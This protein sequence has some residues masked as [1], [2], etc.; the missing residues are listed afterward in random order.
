MANVSFKRGTAAQLGQLTSF[1]EGAFYLTTDTNRLY[2]ANSSTKLSDLNKYVRVVKDITEANALT[3]TED[4]DFVYINEGN[5]FAVKKNGSWT[6]VNPDTNT[7]IDT[8]V[9]GFT[10]GSST[11]KDGAIT[12]PITISQKKRNGN[13][14]QEATPVK[15][16]IVI[17]AN[18]LS[19]ATGISVGLDGSVDSNKLTLTPSGAGANANKKV[20]ITAG[21]NVSITNDASSGITI[22]AT[23][24]T[25]TLEA[26]KTTDQA[27]N[28]TLVL[29]KGNSTQNTITLKGEDEGKIS[30]S[31]DDKGNITIAHTDLNKPTHENKSFGASTDNTTELGFGDGNNGTF[32]AVESITSPDG[33]ITGY[34]TKTYKMP[35][36]TKHTIKNVSITTN[37]KVSVT[38]DNNQPVTSDAKLYYTIG[39]ED[40]EKK[41]VYIGN[42]LDVYTTGEID[43]KLQGINAMVYRGTVVPE[44][45]TGNKL[46]KSG[47]Q[48]GDTYMVSASGSFVLN[49]NTVPQELKDCKAGDLL[50]ATGEETEGVIPSN[51]LVWTYVPS[52]DDTDTHYNLVTVAAKEGAQ[53]KLTNSVNN[54]F[55]N[56]N[57]VSDGELAKVAYDSSTKEVKIS[58]E[59]IGLAT[60]ITQVNTPVST[61]NGG[62]FINLTGLT[63]KNGHIAK[64]EQQTVNLPLYTFAADDSG[65]TN[66]KAGSTTLGSIKFIDGTV[67]TAQYDKNKKA[68]KINHANVSPTISKPGTN[69]TATQLSYGDEIIAVT[70]AEVSEQGHITALTAKKYKMPNAPAAHSYSGSVAKDKDGIINIS[71]AL[72]QGNTDLGTNT[73][74]IVSDS[75]STKVDTGKKQITVELEWGSFT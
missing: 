73:I 23:D 33:H 60:E 54:N 72:K 59:T 6:Q 30:V 19:T 75:L 43:K 70:D 66:F 63:L 21:S 10:A 9:S 2:V 11:S 29:K 27:P 64:I 25:Y 32:T 58:H 41:T 7:D 4:G 37:G 52:G 51:K 39:K 3:G 1:V 44:A 24:S 42:P 46:P 45:S 22:S 35:S 18:S 48:N 62:N 65:V 74:K 15:G 49:S 69:T 28:S 61:S 14:E 50:I 36:E 8:Y 38:L 53:I 17:S 55:D 71:G 13:A 47:V 31:T 16:N 68:Y 67:T 20:S 26:P 34:A 40:N 5:I 56:V 57:I 12:I